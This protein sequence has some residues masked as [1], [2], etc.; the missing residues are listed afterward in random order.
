MSAEHTPVP[1]ERDPSG[2][3]IK[4]V[5]ASPTTD[6][7]VLF[8]VLALGDG[9]NKDANADLIVRAVNCHEELVDLVHE[10]GSVVSEIRHPG[11]TE[12]DKAVKRELQNLVQRAKDVFAKTTS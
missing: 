5:Y 2:M 9:E 12:D 4:S 11:E 8:P 3:A 10:L 6:L 7:S 1:W